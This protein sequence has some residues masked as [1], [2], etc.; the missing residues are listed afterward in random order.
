MEQVRLAL[1]GARTEI[2]RVEL[3]RFL[4]RHA[5][6]CVGGEDVAARDDEAVEAELRVDGRW[7]RGRG[8][9]FESRQRRRRR[10]DRSEEHT[11]EHPSLMRISYA[12]ICLKEKNI[13]TRTIG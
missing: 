9:R 1:P 3:R 12:V 10:H 11:S 2:E 4:H 13:I 7:C 5:A 8:R 6:R